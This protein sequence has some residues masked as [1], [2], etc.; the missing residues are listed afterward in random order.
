MANDK[1]HTGNGRN[2]EQAYRELL[3]PGHGQEVNGEDERSDEH[4]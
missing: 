1:Q 3:V 4:D 2:D